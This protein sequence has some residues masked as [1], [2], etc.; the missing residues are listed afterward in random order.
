[1]QLAKLSCALSLPFFVRVRYGSNKWLRAFVSR[2]KCK[3]ASGN[4][5]IGA[6]I[7]LFRGPVPPLSIEIYA[8]SRSDGETA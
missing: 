6:E 8:L 3:Y 4:A 2:V 7:N 1:M 5:N